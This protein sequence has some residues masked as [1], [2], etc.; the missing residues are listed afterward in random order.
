MR[1]TVKALA[2]PIRVGTD[3]LG[4]ST[5]RS[6][7]PPTTTATSTHPAAWPRSEPW[8]PRSWWGSEAD[9]FPQPD[10]RPSALAMGAFPIERGQGGRRSADRAADLLEAGWSLAI[11]PEGGRSPDGWGTRDRRAPPTSPPAPACRCRCTSGDQPHLRQGDGGPGPAPGSPSRVTVCARPT[12]REHTVRRPHRRRP[13][14]PTTRR[15]G[16]DWWTTET[17][18]RCPMPPL[19]HR[20][21]PQLLAAPGV[22]PGRR[23]GRKGPSS[24]R[25]PGSSHTVLDDL[26]AQNA[27]NCQNP[28]FG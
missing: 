11:F 18:R 10:S 20:P 2:D 12:T 15:A 14:P 9:T 16:S 5:A 21:D 8:R 17:A 7:S 25:W 1:A 23:R 13:S 26:W 22:S 3:R 27:D 19:A 4:A 24:P 6:S 28:G